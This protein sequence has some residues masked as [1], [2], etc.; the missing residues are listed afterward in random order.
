MMLRGVEDNRM[1]T[2]G[3]PSSFER[4]LRDISNGIVPDDDNPNGRAN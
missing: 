4:F 2:G 3:S 1:T